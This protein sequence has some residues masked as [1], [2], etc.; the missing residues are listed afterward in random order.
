MR[1]DLAKAK[2]YAERHG[3]EVYYGKATDLINDDSVDAV[4]VATPPGGDRVGIARMVAAAQ[5]P[6]GKEFT[7]RKSKR[8]RA[9]SPRSLNG[10]RIGTRQT[11]GKPDMEPR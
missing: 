4:Y 3:V 2:D 5:K 1:R 6:C 9:S 7:I 10:I 11:L 8:S